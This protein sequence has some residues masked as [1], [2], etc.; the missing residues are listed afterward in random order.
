MVSAVITEKKTR[1]PSL[2]AKFG[3]FIQF[4]YFLLKTMSQRATEAGDAPI[5][6]AALAEAIHLR[7]S[8]ADQQAFVQSFFDQS[9]DINKE[10]R[11]LLR[12]KKAK[13]SKEAKEPKKKRAK[14]AIV[15]NG[16]PDIVAEIVA[17]ANQEPVSLDPAH[18]VADQATMP[19]EKKTKAKKTAPNTTPADSST[20][21]PKEDTKIPAKKPRKV[22][23]A[24]VTTPVV[25]HP[26]VEHTVIENTVEEEEE[27][28][29]KVD[30]CII[31]GHKRLIDDEN[32]VYDFLTKDLIG[33]FD[34]LTKSIK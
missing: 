21:E 7:D 29:V 1:A 6:D 32:N 3:K 27:E 5:E 34:P 16:Q 14:K 9:K 17:L 11:S 30:V 31:D 20:T 15:S 33:V 12:A 22:K 28:E 10:I 8:V 2:P 24:L 23:A 4:G 25:E 26:V 13:E 18:I 19:V